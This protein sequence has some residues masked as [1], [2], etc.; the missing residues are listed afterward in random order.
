MVGEY[1]A[2]DNDIVELVIFLKKHGVRHFI[3]ADGVV[4]I[5]FQSGPFPAS[6]YDHANSDSTF[7]DETSSYNKDK[8]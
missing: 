8:N 1:T 6:A 5:A 4:D 3:L 7:S 2:L